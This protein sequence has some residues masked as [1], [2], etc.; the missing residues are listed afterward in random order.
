MSASCLRLLEV[1]AF[2]LCSRMWFLHSSDLGKL[3]WIKT[4][5]DAADRVVK[6][7]RNHQFTQALY[8]T[9]GKE[10]ELIRPGT[11]RFGTNLLMIERL[12]E[13]KAALQ[14]LSMSLASHVHKRACTNFTT[15]CHLLSS[16]ALQKT[17]V[18]EKYDEWAESHTD[19]TITAKAVKKDCL[20]S[21]FWTKLG[22]IRDILQPVF[23]MLRKVDTPKPNISKVYNWGSLLLDK[24]KK[25]TLDA[26]KMK[27]VQRI[28]EERRA[29][30]CA[31]FH[32]AAHALDPEYLSYD[33]SECTQALLNIVAKLT[34][35]KVSSCFGCGT[36][37]CKV[38]GLWASR[39]EVS[40]MSDPCLK[41]L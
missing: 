34:S 40:C 27:A 11:T 26:A 33:R 39:I 7:I 30:L 29:A 28:V 10:K 32:V 35:S 6:F 13:V 5:V 3:P 14:E 19:Y 24:V 4:G 21:E 8:R 2:H 16:L 1:E 18:D 25:L 36:G 37:N 38:P 23:E 20:S 41:L 17:V 31:D 9:Y 15:V 22:L 12:Q